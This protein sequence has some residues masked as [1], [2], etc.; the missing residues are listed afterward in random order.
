MMEYQESS[1]SM[2][3]FN[4]YG[5]SWSRNNPPSAFNDDV[6]ILEDSSVDISLIGFDV[7]NEFPQDGSETVLIIQEPI[8]G[9]IN[10]IVFS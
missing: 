2:I 9:E 5:R 6:N 7:F 4:L 1:V 8:N 10:S 3:T